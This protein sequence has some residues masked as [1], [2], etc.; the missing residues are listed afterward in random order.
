MDTLCEKSPPDM[1]I[2]IDISDCPSEIYIGRKV[3]FYIKDHQDNISKFVSEIE[4]ISTD[5]IDIRIPGVKEFKHF[6]NED[7][8]DKF[9]AYIQN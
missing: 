2:S 3:Y 9:I 6:W 8:A 4:I 1:I 7:E 5:W